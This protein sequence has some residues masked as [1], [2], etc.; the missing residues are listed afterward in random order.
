MINSLTLLSVKRVS[1]GTWQPVL[2]IIPGHPLPSLLV[3]AWVKYRP[4]DPDAN[5]TEE[6]PTALTM[7]GPHSN[8]A[9]LWD[10]A[11][12]WLLDEDIKPLEITQ[13]IARSEPT[14]DRVGFSGTGW[15]GH[16]SPQIAASS[17]S[18]LDSETLNSMWTS[19]SQNAI[20]SDGL[21]PY[22]GVDWSTELPSPQNAASSDYFFR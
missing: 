16:P 20:S 11:E 2:G 1:R 6:L 18:V 9:E 4:E 3:G 19:V 12:L 7:R 22:H 5:K 15:T 17:K 13:S 10:S 8:S 14:L 21:W